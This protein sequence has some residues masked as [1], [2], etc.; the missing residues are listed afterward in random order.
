MFLALQSKQNFFGMLLHIKR[1]QVCSRAGL[2][3]AV[4][5]T[6]TA[7]P[8]ASGGQGLAAT[9][10]PMGTNSSLNYEGSSAIYSYQSTN[11]HSTILG[12]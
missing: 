2:P 3:N 9:L 12:A 8:E 11:E 1:Q 5:S 7:I 10:T 6:S 4:L